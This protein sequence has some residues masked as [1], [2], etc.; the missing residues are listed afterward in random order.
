M[1]GTALVSDAE[2][3]ERK[4]TLLALGRRK[5]VLAQ[6]RLQA[7]LG[8]PGRL[9]GFI[10]F[11]RYFWHILEPNTPLVEGMPFY[12]IIAHLEAVTRGEIRRLL[13]NVSPG[14]AKSLLVNV[15]WPAWEWGPAN[16]PWIRY[17]TFSYAAYLTERDNQRMLDVIK[18]PEYRELWGD[19]F[20]LTRDQMT[21]PQNDAKGWKFSS[22]MKGVGTGERGHRILAD[23]LHSVKEGESETIRSETVRWV[24]EGMSNRLND[25]ELGVI[26]MIGQRVHEEDA[27]QAVLDAELGYVHLCIPNEFDPSRACETP[28]WVDPRTED[29]ELA[30]PER[31]PANVVAEIKRTLGPTAYSSQYQQAP[32]PR[33]GAIIKRDWWVP[34]ELE[35]GKPFRHKFE[36]I[37]ASLDPA[38]TTKQEN[39]PSGFTVWGVFHE[40]GMPHAVMLQAWR[41]WLD[42][43]GK[44]MEQG[45]TESNLAFQRRTS[46][47]WGLVEWVAYECKRLKVNKLLIEDKASGHSVVQEMLRL[48]GEDTWG[49]Q[50]YPVGNLDKRARAFAIQHLFA[51]GRILAPASPDGN[52]LVWRDWAE[53]AITEFEKFRG[54][55]GDEDNIVD[56]GVQAIKFLR[57]NDLLI[58]QEEK[59]LQDRAA[60]MHKGPR[61]ALYEV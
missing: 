42:L 37:L 20:R 46:K 51:D 55:P 34:Y 29:G 44:T 43:H 1:A 2:I 10:H 39:D 21:K 27:S 58:R 4:A 16:M 45:A 12:A 38:Y 35:L 48:Y 61:K 14:S 36:F 52:L 50:L 33:G 24:R 18:S 23:D 49:T 9:G 3:A 54:L 5:H 56:S 28:C 30:W 8:A 47:D 59:A 22:S 32:S 60:A 15:L 7:D 11:V 53:V 19:R 57:D 41:K 25:M 26:I 17:V 6:H 13:I 31:F 40:K